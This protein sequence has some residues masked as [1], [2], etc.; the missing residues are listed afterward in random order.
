MV[1]SHIMRTTLRSWLTNRKARTHVLAA[2]LSSSLQDH[3]LNRDVER[4][5]RLVQHQQARPAG[6]GAGDADAGLL[7]ARELVRE[8]VQQFG[9]R[10]TRSA[11]SPTRWRSAGPSACRAS[12]ISG[13]AMQSK[14]EKRG[15]RLSFGSWKTIWMSRRCGARWKSR[16]GDGRWTRRRR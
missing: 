2:Q 8:A 6:D 1:R 10:P 11:H 15:L 9:G 7:A 16:A 4:G 5:R 12:R 13:C 14:A 3:R